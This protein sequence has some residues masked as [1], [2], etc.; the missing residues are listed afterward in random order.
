MFQA[1]AAE[2][3]RRGITVSLVCDNSTCN[4]VAG[5]AVAV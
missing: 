5:G 3:A 1:W 2:Y 4:E